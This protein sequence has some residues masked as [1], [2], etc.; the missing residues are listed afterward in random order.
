MHIVANRV[1]PGSLFGWSDPFVARLRLAG[2]P[3]FPGISVIDAGKNR[4][5]K[6]IFLTPDKRLGRLRGVIPY[7]VALSPDRKRLYVAESGINA[8]GVIDVPSLIQDVYHYFGL[9]LAPADVD[10]A[11]W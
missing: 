3:G 10:V 1:F 5:V 9:R 7:G 6:N 8:V 2:R 11:R 4:V